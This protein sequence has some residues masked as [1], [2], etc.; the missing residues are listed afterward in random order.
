MECPR[1][2]ESSNV[3][4]PYW[5]E[6]SCCGYRTLC[7]IDVCTPDS[8]KIQY[9]ANLSGRISSMLDVAKCFNTSCRLDGFVCFFKN[10]RPVIPCKA[11]TGS[12]AKNTT[13]MKK[14]I[15]LKFVITDILEHDGLPLT[16]LGTLE[17]RLILQ[18]AFTQHDNI[19]LA[20]GEQVEGLSHISN[21]ARLFNNRILLKPLDG[22]YN[23][24][25]L[26]IL[27]CNLSRYPIVWK[28]GAMF[29]R[30]GEREIA[31]PK[32]FQHLP[33]LDSL[34]VECY[35]NG[36]RIKHCNIIQYTN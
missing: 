13:T 30:I 22:V 10:N 11:I 33:K 18:E 12:I 36:H 3:T 32:R 34:V 6:E 25:V 31:I 7:K 4:G 8:I 23:E 9:L 19:F 2:R 27:F 21:V 17:R 16:S 14:D 20:R 35:Y 5:G 26:W 24:T 29:A 1:I 15:D 28:N